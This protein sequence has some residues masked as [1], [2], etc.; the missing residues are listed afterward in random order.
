V[1]SIESVPRAA[2]SKKPSPDR[3]RTSAQS[4]PILRRADE[5]VDGLPRR[6]RLL[7]L[8]VFPVGCGL[9]TLLIGQDVNFDLFNYHFYNAWAFLNGQ[10]LTNVFPGNI[11]TLINPL[12]DVPTYLLTVHTPP[13]FEAFVVGFEQGLCPLVVYLIARRVVRP[14]SLALAAVIAAAVAGGFVSELGNDMGDSIVA[15]PLLLGVLWAV[16][17]I[18][19]RQAEP[20]A[21]AERE[22]RRRRPSREARWWL[23]SGLAAGVGAGLKFAELPVAVGLVLGSLVAFG[24]WRD[25]LRSFG[26]SVLGA[27]IGV[28]A[29]AG[30]WS[31]FLWR[32]YGDP[33][34]F[35]GGS[36]WFSHFAYAAANGETVRKVG[37]PASPEQVLYWPVYWFFHPLAASEIPVR[38]A[39]ISIAYVLLVALLVLACIRGARAF[40]GG[41]SRGTPA[42]P[43]ARRL[44]PAD[45]VDASVDRYFITTFVVTLVIWVKVFGVYRYLIP[46]ELLAPIVVISA[47]RRLATFVGDAGRRCRVTKRVLAPL[48][49]AVCALCVATESPSSY[50]LRTGFGSTYFEVA[51]PAMLENGKLD[52]L[53][54]LSYSPESFVMPLLHGRFIGIGGIDGRE[55]GSMLSPAT[56]TLLDRAFARVRHGGGTVIGYWIGTPITD[57]AS[58]L[59]SLGEP[60][61]H[62][63]GCV[64]ETLHIGTGYEPIGFCR[65]AR[66]S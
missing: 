29:T 18:Q 49:V 42:V 24:P 5:W 13:R 4:A 46:L 28:A 55:G 60:G 37:L 3:P 21:I 7:A 34:A 57:G 40:L 64:T 11:Q 44:G 35:T 63:V 50:W 14:R 66:A 43:R 15:F 9:A 47:G 1:T 27:V 23:A 30:Y 2:G 20:D 36:F 10:D 56:H 33:F 39:S 61:E 58:L 22:A 19:I 16:I 48:F 8:L 25:R 52:V 12:L 59:A 65:F 32:H 31:Y 6:L 41:R 54:E 17:A 51:T 53:V 62:Q 26:A 45:R 38:E